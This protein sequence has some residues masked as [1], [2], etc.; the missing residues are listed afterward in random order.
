MINTEGGDRACGHGS[1]DGSSTAASTLLID[2]RG[3]PIPQGSKIAVRRGRRTL[4]IDDNAN[5]LHK[6]RSRVADAAKI[7]M[8]PHRPWKPIT[9]PVMVEI[10]YYLPRPANHYGTGRNGGTLKPTAP[11]YAHTKPDRDKLDRAINDALT[12]AGVWKDDNLNVTGGSRKLYAGPG[13]AP[14]AIIMITRINAER[15]TT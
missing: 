1:P 4:I 5:E 10:T 14:G 2:V 15:T 7:A 9:D 12:I 11:V 8:H 13:I 3:V 6:W